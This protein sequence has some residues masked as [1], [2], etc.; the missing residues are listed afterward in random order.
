MTLFNNE[1][2]ELQIETVTSK[3]NRKV[4]VRHP[5]DRG[6]ERRGQ[7]AVGGRPRAEG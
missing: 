5:G 7:A 1:I 6:P 3:V 4:I 2:T